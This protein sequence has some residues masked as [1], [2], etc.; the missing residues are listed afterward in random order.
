MKDQSICPGCR[1]KSSNCA[2]ECVCGDRF[3]EYI[4]ESEKMTA[5]IK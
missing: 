3:V 2:S 5:K 4:E 1:S